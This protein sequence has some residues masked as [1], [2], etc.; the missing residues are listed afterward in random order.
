M[1]PFFLV[2]LFRVGFFQRQLTLWQLIQL[3]LESR[4]AVRSQL[5]PSVYS[6]SSPS[7]GL[8]VVTQSTHLSKEC[9]PQLVSNPH[10]PE[11]RSPKVAELQMHATTRLSAFGCSFNVAWVYV[12]TF[13]DITVV[14]SNPQKPQIIH[15]VQCIVEIKEST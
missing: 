1:L 15:I 8:R 12:V 5:G 2:T 3:D 10:R 4:F 14:Y 7:A 13:V 6:G 11:I 9:Y